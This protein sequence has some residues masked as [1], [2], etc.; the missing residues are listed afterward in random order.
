[1]EKR[2]YIAP[3]AQEIEIVKCDVICSSLPVVDEEI[4]TGGR[5]LRNERNSWGNLWKE[6]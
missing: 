5:T 2:I 4:N 6:Q 3:V 1:M